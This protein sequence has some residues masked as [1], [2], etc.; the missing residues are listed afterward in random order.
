[1]ADQGFTKYISD[2]AGVIKE[3]GEDIMSTT[4]EI[5]DLFEAILNYLTDDQ[6][7]GEIKTG[8]KDGLDILLETLEAGEVFK[9]DALKKQFEDV[10]DQIG[11]TINIDLNNSFDPDDLLQSIT[12]LIP[13]ETFPA[14]LAKL[15]A[16]L[17]QFFK[18]IDI[19]DI[20]IGVKKI[21]DPVEKLNTTISSTTNQNAS[22]DQSTSS[23]SFGKETT[24]PAFETL[25]DDFLKKIIGKVTNQQFS[26]DDVIEK[27][28][29]TIIESGFYNDLEEKREEFINTVTADGV[30]IPKIF[31]AVSQLLLDL[32]ESV[33]GAMSAIIEF[34]LDDLKD[35]LN[36]IKKELFSE[37]SGSV[38]KSIFEQFNIKNFTPKVI[39]VP[40]FLMS[41]PFTIFT[42]T[43]TGSKPSFPNFSLDAADDTNNKINGSLQICKTILPVIGLGSYRLSKN[44]KKSAIAT[45]AVGDVLGLTFD[46]LG[47]VYDNPDA[48]DKK[49]KAF[50]M[51]Q[52]IKIGLDFLNMIYKIS[53]DY[54][55]TK[56]STTL[57][58]KVD[59][60]A[61]FILGVLTL[62]ELYNLMF[63][64][65]LDNSDE[66]EDDTRIK[67]GYYLDALP[68]ILDGI[69]S[70]AKIPKDAQL[71][72]K[73]DDDEKLLTQ[74]KDDLVPI[75]T[76][77]D[78]VAEIEKEAYN[79]FYVEHKNG[80]SDLLF[81]HNKLSGI[82]SVNDETK[83]LLKSNF[84]EKTQDV[85]LKAT[86]NTIINKIDQ[87]L[88]KVNETQLLINAHQSKLKP[89]EVLINEF[90]KN[91][92][93]IKNGINKK[94]ED[95]KSRI[96]IRITPTNEKDIKSLKDNFDQNLHILNGYKKS[97]YNITIAFHQN[98]LIR[99]FFVDE[100]QEL[101]ILL[102]TED[103]IASLES[104]VKLDSFKTNFEKIERDK[105]TAP[106]SLL[107]I[108]AQELEVKKK[109]EPMKNQ[110]EYYFPITEIPKSKI[111]T[112][113]AQI[114]KG[115]S[116]IEKLKKGRSS[117][118]D[119]K[120]LNKEI[121]RLDYGNILFNAVIQ[122]TYGSL[123]VNTGIDP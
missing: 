62:F 55:D 77:I 24:D 21:N 112:L 10:V 5:E 98:E 19:S 9:I 8:F 96:G 47:Q 92:P 20:R 67:I 122:L 49:Q 94:I 81:L 29:T 1:M 74:L 17:K 100:I 28:E 113:M 43:I 50:W 34:I 44:Y 85:A 101:S 4:Q 65:V 31:E 23:S 70:I 78:G 75:N 83:S 66:A 27:L 86:L 26:I 38:V 93:L 108:T 46:I 87:L 76:K 58:H 99:N 6:K 39:S 110:L 89:I 15:Y 51:S 36:F 106:I 45:E 117:K 84:E 90:N 88:A 97:M 91:L 61:K 12:D 7:L 42:K 114:S 107:K 120:K 63:L 56:T 109:E 105:L 13:E 104:L 69:I 111:E 79:K 48:E 116:A 80:I 95:Y 71:E 16:T 72:Q 121:A 102:K 53:I 22:T 41:V 11:D 68:G 35:I 59:D 14:D 64:I 73:E 82:R 54:L 33:I 52:N 60:R 25:F 123:Q 119:L 115:L 18:N 30:T 2:F 3:N 37:E 103:L 40:A 57:K 118:A 32:I